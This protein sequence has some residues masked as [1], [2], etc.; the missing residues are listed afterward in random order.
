MRLDPRIEEIISSQIASQFPDFYRD[1]GPI[2]VAFVEAYYRWLESEG[3]ALYHSRRIPA[4]KDVDTTVD[5]FLVHFTKKYLNGIQLE[6]QSNVRQ[7]IK[8]SLDLYRTKGTERSIDLLFR[9]VFGVG[10]DIYFPS[11]D[12]FRL[13]S[14][15]WI[16]PT[17]LEVYDR[18]RMNDLLG[19]QI[20]GIY[21]GARGFVERIVRK[22][23]PTKFVDVI[24]LSDLKGVFQAGEPINK[25]FSPF[26]EAECPIVIGSLSSLTVLSGGSDYQVGD[27]VD[28]SSAFGHSGKA[29]VTSVT[30]A[31]G[32]VSLELLDGGFGYTVNAEVLIS[33]SVIT[34]SGM[35]G[36]SGEY[37][38]LF[39]QVTQS[40]ASVDYEGAN[41]QF[42][43]GEQV[44]TYH[45]NN[46]LRGTAYVSQSSAANG[47]HGNL[48]LSVI[49]GNVD[50]GPFYTLA[51]SVTANQ[52]TIVWSNAVG[53]VI[54]TSDITLL[55]SSRSGEF[56]VG[57]T[58][59][60]G[61][62]RAQVLIASGDLLYLANLTGTFSVGSN[63]TGQFSQAVGA[64]AQV[65]IDVGVMVSSGEFQSGD[66]MYAVHGS[67]AVR[68]TTVS[69]G[70][71][72]DIEIGTLDEM[73]TTD[74]N[75]D[76]LADYESLELDALAYGFPGDPSANSAS[77]FDTYLSFDTYEIGRVATVNLL[78]PGQDYAVP[79][80][81]RI[82]EPAIYGL[83]KTGYSLD[84]SGATGT[85]GVGEIVEQNDARGQVLT[86]N[87]SVITLKRLSVGSDFVL[88][89][90]STTKISGLSSGTQANVVSVS[91]LPEKPMS[92][93]TTGADAV[94]FTESTTE[95]G[96]VSTLEVIDSG[97]GYVDLGQVSF[98]AEGR[99]PGTARIRSLTHGIGQGYYKRKGGFLSS[100]KYLFDGD[101]WQEFSYEVRSS[102][103]V[104]EYR[105]MLKQVIHMAGT[106]M[107]GALVTDSR[108]NSPI[109][110]ETTVQIRRPPTYLANTTLVSEAVL[111]IEGDL[112]GSVNA[113][114]GSASSVL[115]IEGELAKSLGTA[116]LSSVG[117]L[118]PV[119]VFNQPPSSE[120]GSWEGYNMR[121]IIP[122]SVMPDVTGSAVTITVQA[123]TTDGFSLDSMYVGHAAVSGDAMDFDGNQQQVLFSGS[124]S[125]ALAT[126]VASVSDAITFS[127]DGTKNLVF[128]VHFNGPSK[129]AWKGSIDTGHNIRWKLG[130]SEASVTDVTGYSAPSTGQMTLITKVEVTP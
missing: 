51:N 122:A 94:L 72:L 8:H 67:D 44:F 128:S 70:T 81:V 68:I 107:F 24:F 75:T 34:L 115:T 43:P 55:V 79:P 40:T 124:G 22:K 13:S 89:S 130:A 88:T 100:N 37:F 83:A 63:V 84:F 30:E 21:S 127:F 58:I 3:Q 45:A 120:T 9:L 18:G 59:V 66:F 64:A 60:Q 112:S 92:V 61:N 111:P 6:T 97:L 76:F 35:P 10:A 19:T 95:D 86:S 87:G 108:L 4:Y 93:G 62:T 48:V 17:Y 56:A 42:N 99:G 31:D 117:E 27:I 73:E 5:D 121:M 54:G 114:T 82:Y 38:R 102:R 78:N 71:G 12:I 105:D 11:K 7:L 29:R 69:T 106:K 47:T 32:G 41:G 1:E 14:G 129:T 77:I 53:N 2:F 33:N 125:L 46:L 109:E 103:A 98:S 101:Y 49:S 20:E 85:F 25:S 126:G 90:N 113:V 52:D 119:I 91:A 16:R 39:D 65:A 118:G 80:V 57:E 26:E 116:T 104:D 123:G 28:V 15:Q 96:Y 36:S 50:G 23:T 74:I 110:V